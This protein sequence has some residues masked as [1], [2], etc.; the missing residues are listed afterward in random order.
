MIEVLPDFG[1]FTAFAF[2]A[3]IACALWVLARVINVTFG[4]LPYIGGWV[5][6]NIVGWLNVGR[7][8]CLDSAK[9]AW[10]AGVAMIRWASNYLWN[11]FV[12]AVETFETVAGTIQHIALDTIPDAVSRLEGYVIQH[13]NAAELRAE[14]WAAARFDS[15]RADVVNA[16]RSAAAAIQ[17]VDTD[18]TKAVAQAEAK[19]A[20]LSAGVYTDVEDW[21]KIA[22]ETVWPDADQSVDA[23]RDAIGDG[24]PWL[25]DLLPAL[26]GAG[27][28]GLLGTLIRSLAGAEVA[29]N[30][31]TECT[32]PMCQN[33]GQFGRDLANLLGDVSLAA[34]L[35]WLAFGVADPGGWAADMNA[36]ALPLGRGLVDVASNVLG[37]S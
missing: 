33:L 22:V 11:T 26:A 28:A 35:A 12:S 34:F 16:E 25:K 9:G 7:V 13:A 23:L 24:F 8:Y 5:K 14:Q 4:E 31:A 6:R 19:A 36:V 2:L 3:A 20:A 32:V 17:R 18:L 15:I 21:G 37:E 10:G 1:A 29:T 27:A 30:L